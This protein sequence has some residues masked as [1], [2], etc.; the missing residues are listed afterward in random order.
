MTQSSEAIDVVYTWVDDSFPGYLEELNTY[1][2]DPRDTNPNRTRDNLD[3]LR[4]SMRSI[5]QNLPQIRRIYLV[6]CRPQVPSWLN[7]E[8]PKIHV[9]HH[10]EIMSPDILPTYNSFAIVS[11]LHKIPG[12]SEKFIYFEDD[13][14][15]MPPNLMDALFAPDGRP[16]VH[17]D[18][19]TVQTLDKLN[20][21]TSS[22][23]NLALANSDAA[24]TERFGAR[25]RQHIIHGPHV[26]DIGVCKDMC[27]VFATQFDTTRHSKFRSADNIAPE[28]LACQFAAETEAAVVS[29]ITLSRQIQGYVSIEN[30]KLW[31]WVQLMRLNLR[32][33]LSVTLNDSFGASPNARVEDLARAQLQRWFSVAAPWER[34]LDHDT[35]AQHTSS[36]QNYDC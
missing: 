8:H 31:T 9:I 20:P 16:W 36:G 19:R 7:S 2:A 15:A 23:W 26:F 21:A 18:K 6:T 1:V 22:P 29:D 27:R 4:F 24:L 32:R 11:H 17:L 35:S 28:F 25:P 14:L 34:P 13:M 30:F 10:D 33:P 3:V 5:W 12:L